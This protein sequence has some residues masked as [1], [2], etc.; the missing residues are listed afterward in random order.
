VEKRTPD[1][2]VSVELRCAIKFNVH[3]SLCR[4]NGIRGRGPRLASILAGNRI[5]TGD[6]S[7]G[8]DGAGRN[9]GRRGKV[10]DVPAARLTAGARRT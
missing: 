7:G 3:N 4:S 2:K 9:K 8:G 10:L 1:F 6:L 5:F